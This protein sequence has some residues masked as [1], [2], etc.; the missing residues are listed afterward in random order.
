MNDT[1][2][3]IYLEHHQNNRGNDFGLFL[4]ERGKLFSKLIGINKNII[5]IGCRDGALS[6][7]YKENNN[8]LGLD[9]DEDAMHRANEKGINTLLTDLNADWQIDKENSF[10]IVIASEIIEHLYNPNKIFYRLN[11]VLKTD[12]ILIGSVPNAFRVSARIR[13]FFGRKK[14]T[15]LEDPTHINHF[16]LNEIKNL[17]IEA[18]FKKIEF[19]TLPSFRG[20]LLAKYFPGLFS[21]M[22]IFSAKK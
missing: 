6:K 12:G 7:Y 17:L 22:I 20:K 2:S 19:Y 5:D 1:L 14:G 18:G 11:T 21:Y 8:L 9:I 10:D 13:L 3:T 16:S 15:P 4:E